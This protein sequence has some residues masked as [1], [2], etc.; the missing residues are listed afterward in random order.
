MQ[1]TLVF[2]DLLSWLHTKLTWDNFPFWFPSFDRVDVAIMHSSAVYPC[3]K[4]W[5]DEPNLFKSIVMINPAGHRTIKAMRPEWLISNL[6][7]MN[8]TPLGRKIFN[9]VGKPFVATAGVAVSVENLSN[10]VLACITMYLAQ[11]S[12]VSDICHA[13]HICQTNNTHSM[14]VEGLFWVVTSKE[15]T[16]VLHI[17]WEG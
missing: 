7:R 8:L 11:T 12:R 14:A 5:K 6:A 2:K 15:N 16:Y 1:L 17:Q 9:A 3:M 10:A 13:G 4:V